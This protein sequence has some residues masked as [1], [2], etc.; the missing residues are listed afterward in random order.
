MKTVAIVG[1]F[2]GFFLFGRYPPCP[3][4]L[5]G[6][7]L[8]RA[9]RSL[10]CYAPLRTAPTV[11]PLQSLTQRTFICPNFYVKNEQQAFVLLVFVKSSKVFVF[12]STSFKV[13]FYF[14]TRLKKTLNIKQQL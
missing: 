11:A 7:G 14:S 6:V 10:R 8:F 5:R 4:G 13:F 2:C 9:P 1:C 3:P 12:L